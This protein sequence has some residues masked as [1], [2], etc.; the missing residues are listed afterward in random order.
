MA[1]YMPV[2]PMYLLYHRADRH[3]MH[4][5]DSVWTSEVI[6]RMSDNDRP[7]IHNDNIYKK[8]KYGRLSLSVINEP[9]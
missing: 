1:V 7:P 8:K 9:F 4:Y 5:L 2:L 6:P 3:I